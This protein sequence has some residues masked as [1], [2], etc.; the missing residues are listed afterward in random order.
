[1]NSPTFA[2]MLRLGSACQD[3]VGVW[4]ECWH[5]TDGAPYGEQ[6]ELREYL[7]LSEEQYWRWLIVGDEVLDEIMDGDA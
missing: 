4:V 1:M 6:V 5:D 3:D 7:G 2:E